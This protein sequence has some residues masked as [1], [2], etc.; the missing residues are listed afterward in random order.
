MRVVF[1]ALL[2]PPILFAA[3]NGRLS[4]ETDPRADIWID[5]KRAG[6]SPLVKI[7]IMAG[8][9]RIQYR[10]PGGQF[11]FDLVI[12]ADKHFQCT[13][14]FETGESRCSEISLQKPG[15]TGKIDLISR[16]P[17]EAY[18]GGKLLGKTPFEKHVVPAGRH[19]IEFR[20]PDFSPIEKEVDV[21][22]GTRVRVEVD[23][24]PAETPQPTP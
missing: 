9:H 21:E 13:Y 11:E 4:I 22:P 12:E 8:K 14:R 19:R 1:F 17:S 6:K 18:L 2:V 20:H 15:A 5:G 24:R 23:F 7:P 16:P 10:Q 3:S